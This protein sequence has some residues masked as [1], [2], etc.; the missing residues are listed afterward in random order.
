M[1]SGGELNLM[2]PFIKENI[3]CGV[4]TT[5]YAD[6]VILD[7]NASLYG[8]FYYIAHNPL[9]FLELAWL[10]TISFFGLIRSYYSIPHNLFLILFYYPFYVMTIFGIR[11]KLRNGKKD[12]LFF[13][14]IIFLYWFTTVLTCDDW[15][16][17]FFLTISPFLFLLGMSMFSGSSKKEPA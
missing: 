17:R 10:K 12:L 1:Q 15:H 9:H 4:N 3:I 14:S 8:L 5:A 7:N 2:L 16:D 11:N 13:I 6:I